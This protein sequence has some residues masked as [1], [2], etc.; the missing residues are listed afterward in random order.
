MHTSYQQPPAPVMPVNGFSQQQQLQQPQMGGMNNGVVVMGQDQQVNNSN[1]YG[2]DIAGVAKS[3][4]DA[5]SRTFLC[6]FDFNEMNRILQQQPQQANSA[7]SSSSGSSSASCSSTGSNEIQRIL[8][9]V[10]FFLR[11][12]FKKNLK[13][14]RK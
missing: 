10:S 3:I 13:K 1:Q 5:H 7:T 4:F 2:Y 9:L 14:N 6:Y 8:S 12:C 11:F